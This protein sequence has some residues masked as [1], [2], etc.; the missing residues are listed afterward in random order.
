MPWPGAV[1]LVEASVSLAFPD[2]V[3]LV[4]T[5][6][7]ALVAVRILWNLAS[8]RHRAAYGRPVK[9]VFLIGAVLG[10][11]LPWDANFGLAGALAAALLLLLLASAYSLLGWRTAKSRSLALIWIPRETMRDLFL[12]LSVGAGVVGVVTTLISLAV[13]PLL[14]ITLNSFVPLAFDTISILSALL[15]FT[16]YVPS[17]SNI[18]ALVYDFITHTRRMALE[19]GEPYLDDLDFK[20]IRQRSHYTD[21]EI[22]DAMESLVRKGFASKLS[23]VPVARIVFKVGPYGVRYLKSVWEEVF[24]SMEREKAQLESRM[25]YLRE[26]FRLSPEPDRELERRAK[27]ELA[28]F[29]RTLEELG[30]YGVLMT[31]TG[32]EKL[33]DEL[34]ELEEMVEGPKGKAEGELGAGR[35]PTGG[36]SRSKA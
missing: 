12:Y 11:V 35:A 26:K 4:I 18:Y 8:T 9:L 19:S 22:R 15:E 14:N 33:A 13:I 25:L 34:A 21:F 24:F 28:G 27:D 31:G 7:S 29:R 17:Y 10:A 30:S 23:P 2:L 6:T 20:Q 3:L 32:R 5:F 16:V 1:P 36:E